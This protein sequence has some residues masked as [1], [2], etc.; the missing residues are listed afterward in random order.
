MKCSYISQSVSKHD[1]ILESFSD[2]LTT[3]LESKICNFCSCSYVVDLFTSSLALSSPSCFVLLC[4]V[5]VCRGSTIIG[6]NCLLYYIGVGTGEAPGACAGALT[7]SCIY[8]PLQ[9]NTDQMGE[10]QA[11]LQPYCA[12]DG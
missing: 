4:C 9:C 6:I 3:F 12:K 2:Y 11:R 5:F 1:L 10:E 8:Y 7:A